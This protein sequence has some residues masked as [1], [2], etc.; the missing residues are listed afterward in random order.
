MKNFLILIL[1][2]VFVAAPGDADAKKFS[3]APFCSA[4]ADS[5]I[6]QAVG[7]S[8]CDIL[9][10]ASNLRISLLPAQGDSVP[11]SRKIA[12]KDRRLVS[13]II[14]NPKNFLRDSRVYG[15]FLPQ[16]ELSFRAGRKELTVR[17][18][19]GLRKWGI[20]NSKGECLSMFDLEAD[21]MLRFAALQFPDN[22][23]LSRLAGYASGTLPPPSAQ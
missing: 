10:D 3:P 22:L 17:Y 18:D 14:F 2:A 19:F 7:D 15:I 11:V 16:V 23:L 13:F 4:A 9:A 21:N 6:R 8:V 12:R 1:I 20:F 5:L